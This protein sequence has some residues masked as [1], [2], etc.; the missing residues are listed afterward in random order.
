VIK[1]T[2]PETLDPVRELRRGDEL[3]AWLNHG[4]IVEPR[5]AATVRL[6]T[7]G[8]VDAVIDNIRAITWQ[9]W[10]VYLPQ[11]AKRLGVP[12]VS[13]RDDFDGRGFDAIA[14]ARAW[15][16][17][18]GYVPAYLGDTA[19]GLWLAFKLLALA[20]EP[21]H[22]VLRQGA[23]LAKLVEGELVVQAKRDGEIPPWD[24]PGTYGP[25][26]TGVA[27]TYRGEQVEESY[28]DDAW[29]WENLAHDGDGRY[30]I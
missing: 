30:T 18:V 16:D 25:T 26:A 13:M 24:E 17:H 21:G 28:R 3:W 22:A 6:V 7:P 8:H 11:E 9:R 19:A 10:G 20:G 14:Q 2:S 5:H 4:K 12:W 27:V 23:C 15:G 29:R 1:W